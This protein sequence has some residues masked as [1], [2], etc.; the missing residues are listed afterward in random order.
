MK[1]VNDA[2][3][4]GNGIWAATSGG[5]FY[6]SF[7]DHSY[8]TL[9]KAK[10]LSNN[11]LTAVTIDNNGRIWFGGQEGA[12]DVYD[13]V[14]D[15]FLKKIHDIADINKGQKKINSLSV[16]GDTIFVSTDFGVSLINASDFTFKDTYLKLGSFPSDTKVNNIYLKDVLYVATENGIARQKPGTIN[17]SAPEAWENFNNQQGLPSSTVTK[18]ITYKDSVIAATSS[19]LAVLNNSF[20]NYYLT[21]FNGISIL[22][23]LVRNDSLFIVTK[24]QVSV[25]FNGKLSKPYPSSNISYYKIVTTPSG[26]LYSTTNKGLLRLSSDSVKVF[27]APEGPASNFFPAMSVDKDG[28]LWS[29][30]GSSGSAVGFYKY[31][32]Q[33]WTNYSPNDVPNPS[34]NPAYF[35]TYVSPDNVVY[36]LNWGEGFTRYKDG[37]F[38]LFNAS[39][40]PLGGVPENL[41]FVV[42]SGLT[43]DSKG[44]LWVLTYK[45]SNKTPLYVLRS[46]STWE[47]FSNSK[48][49]S[50]VM[51]GYDILVDQYDTKWMVMS[52]IGLSTGSALYYYN[53]DSPL[54]PDGDYD[55]N[56]LGLIT[57]VH[58]LNSNS[59]NAIA[60][61]RRGELWVGS[62]AGINVI[63]DTREPKSKKITSVEP[64]ST[65]V[66]NCIAVDALNQKW[67]GT[68]QGVYVVSPDGAK[69]VESYTS[70]NSP[71][72]NDI[73][74][75]IAIDNNT[76][77][78]YIGTDYGLTSVTTTAVKPQEGFTEMFV[79]PN[80]VIIEDN[81]SV[82][83]TIEGLV[84]DTDIKV[85][86]ISGKVVNTFTSP[87]AGIAI[88]DGKDLNGN[89]VSSGVYIIVAYDKDGTNLATAKVAII[90]K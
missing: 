53:G 6:Y 59:I 32:R 81:S 70:S 29:G 3:A 10:G 27:F 16:K 69:I 12:I 20:W 8:L 51:Q 64:L 5:A 36:L 13:P 17:L 39:N 49:F 24:D 80:P 9:N 77:T 87:G 86:S 75:S 48:L 72:P 63:S 58:G 79:F 85:L 23:L 82:K 2:C 44:N 43:T 78:V 54:Y 34:K 67:V 15:V 38:K 35:K 61:D 73:I 84:R 11:A 22:D 56:G 65:K 28:N 40:T 26:E 45:S 46:D 66:V 42:V 76:G 19:G 83:I 55:D 89:F 1:N 41:G 25:Y 50:K 33:K 52:E 88:W 7:E 31:D 47:G 71:L 21:Q 57:S 30:S 74:K 68:Q 62:S 37:N 4:S 18:V 90:R 60:L 14:K